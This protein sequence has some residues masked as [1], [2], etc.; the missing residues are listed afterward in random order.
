MTVKK[1][2]NEIEAIVVRTTTNLLGFVSEVGR[3]GSELRLACGDLRANVNTYLRD[4]TFGRRFMICFRL[5][6]D[7]GITIDWMDVVLRQLTNEK[8]TELMAL[9]V[10]QSAILFALAQN[11]RIL[12]KTVFTSRED[13]E[14]MLRRMKDWVDIVKDLAGN[15]MDDM[16]WRALNELGGA[17][18]RYLADVARPLPRML[19]YEI[20]PSPAL[21]IAQYIY[22][23]GERHE[24]LAAENKVVHPAFMPRRIKALSA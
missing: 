17:M 3:P 4:G 1:A 15:E 10:V 24:E 12:R 22:G 11:G 2:L 23:D 19:N 21:T 5:S 7:A 13:C 14:A 16:S 8:P 20:V 9:T 18:T 6:T